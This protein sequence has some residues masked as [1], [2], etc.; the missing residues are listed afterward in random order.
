M[1]LTNTSGGSPNAAL[2]ATAKSRPR[3]RARVVQPAAD[4][5]LNGRRLSRAGCGRLWRPNQRLEPMALWATAQPPPVREQERTSD[6]RPKPGF[7]S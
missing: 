7:C 2:Q 5:R 1:P 6:V 3:L 4:G